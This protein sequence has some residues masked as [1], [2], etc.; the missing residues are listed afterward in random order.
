MAPVKHL[1]GVIW[2]FPVR[3]VRMHAGRTHPARRA[4]RSGPCIRRRRALL[5]ALLQPTPCRAG[6]YDLQLLLQNLALDAFTDLLPALLINCLR[7]HE[8]VG[9]PRR[10]TVRQ[11]GQC[12]SVDDSVVN[13]CQFGRAH[14]VGVLA[15]APLHPVATG[16]QSAT[17]FEPLTYSTSRQE[18]TSARQG[19][20]ELLMEPGA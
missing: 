2:S 5:P 17:W 1:H 19:H 14:H 20:E 16:S 3:F 7:S 12:G 13:G 10:A 6:W 11:C 15:R 8:R 4:A 18:T 9:W